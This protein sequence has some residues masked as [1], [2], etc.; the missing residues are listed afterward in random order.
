MTLIDL[1]VEVEIA[2]EVLKTQFILSQ[3]KWVPHRRLSFPWQ[4][5]VVNDDKKLDLVLFQTMHY[6]ICH[7]V[8]QTYNSNNNTKRK[9]GLISYNQ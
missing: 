4:F 8:H 2:W 6:V 3:K 9:K 1:D 5:F 7:Y